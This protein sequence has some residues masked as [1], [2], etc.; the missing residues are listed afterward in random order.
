MT[1]SIVAPSLYLQF[2]V[3][4]LSEN[5]EKHNDNRPSASAHSL[6]T[7]SLDRTMSDQVCIPRKLDVMLLVNGLIFNTLVDTGASISC[8]DQELV[9]ELGLAIERSNYKS[10]TMAHSNIS[11]S[12]IGAVTVKA[13]VLFPSFKRDTISLHSRF[14]ILPVYGPNADY[15]F[16]IGSDLLL[17]IFP[18]GI[19]PQY[20]GKSGNTGIVASLSSTNIID[21]SL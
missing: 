18:N 11:V 19:P 16:I 13:T 2:L 12:S 14:E 20:L 17:T 7:Q 3:S 10:L 9:K 15:H 21:D 6:Q 1:Y 5:E 8:I 4:H